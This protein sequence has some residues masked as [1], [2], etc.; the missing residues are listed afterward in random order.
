MLFGV[1]YCLLVVAC[2]CGWLL[3]VVRC[4]S[5]VV[6]C[7]LLLAVCSSAAVVCWSVRCPMF[8]F[9]CGSFGDGCY[10]LLLLCDD[11]ACCLLCV[12]LRGLP[13]VCV[14]V[15]VLLF[16]VCWS[17]RVGVDW[18]CECVVCCSVMLAGVLLLVVV[19]C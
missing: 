13:C 2:C 9:V 19:M 6:C 3:C 15:V 14:R 5:I 1:V 17:F 16:V 11:L 10:G 18:L 7:V 8:F 4:V 12:G